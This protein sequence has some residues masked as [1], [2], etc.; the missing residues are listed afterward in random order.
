MEDKLIV[1]GIDEKGY[2]KVYK[3][4]M[5]DPDLP[6]TAK[7]LYA[8]FCS[9]TGSGTTSFPSRDKIM[10]DLHLAKN[11]FTKYL[12]CLLEANYLAR[13]RTAAGNVYE[14]L[15][16][17]KGKDGQVVEMKAEGYGTVPKF[18]MLDARLTVT[19]K[20]I[21]AY[22]CSY[23]G[24][25]NLAYP[26]RSTILHEL[27]IN[28][29]KYYQ[30]YKLLVELGYVTPTQEIGENGQ[31]ASSTYML[32]EILGVDPRIDPEE[33]RKSTAVSRKNAP[34]RK[35][36]DTAESPDSTD[37]STAMSQKSLHGDEAVSKKS[38]HGPMSQ[39]SVYGNLRHPINNNNPHNKQILS[40]DEDRDRI[41]NIRARAREE[42]P[43]VPRPLTPQEEVRALIGYEKIWDSCKGMLI[44]KRL[45]NPDL[46]AEEEEAYLNGCRKILG[47]MVRQLVSMLYGKSPY[48][49][50]GNQ[51][52]KRT[53][54]RRRLETAISR[55]PEAL[56][57][58]VERMAE[59]FTTIRV[60]P[61]YIRKVLFTLA[62]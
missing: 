48:V 42:A 19:A 26:K 44:L 28:T 58:T 2:G 52:Y 9:Y 17:V 53:D 16:T 7:A 38:L 62:A 10:G 4:V 31:F 12:N 21:Y 32:N 60:L 61:A 15:L 13:H 39:K 23:A 11:T 56:C 25:G 14:I 1:V 59:E 50:I 40:S 47:E 18:A 41:S 22:L 27:G 34:C 51:S 55:N 20:A 35:N 5:R 30:H 57:E 33:I 45:L 54:L 36:H 3:H 46:T 8:Y 29:Q 6:L 43:V 24:A 49:K 37:F